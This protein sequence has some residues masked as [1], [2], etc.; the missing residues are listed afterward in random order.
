[1]VVSGGPVS[2]AHV[3]VVVADRL[4]AP[5]RARRLKVWLPCVRPVNVFVPAVPV[6]Q[7]ANAAASTRQEKAALSLAVQLKV[8]VVEVAIAP[9]VAVRLRVGAAVSV[10]Q[11]KLAGVA[12]TL[13]APSTPR[14]AKVCG[15]SGRL[16]SGI[17]TGDAQAAKAAPSRLHSSVAS[18]SV[19]IVKDAAPLFGSGGV[20]VNAVSGA[21]VSTVQL[22]VAGVGSVLPAESLAATLKECEPSARLPSVTGL[23]QAVAAAP[24]SEHWNVDG[25]VDDTNTNCADV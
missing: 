12:S 2:T 3:N 18:G 4:P 25:L 20:P 5:S 10:V 13:P 9:G 21:T 23:V 6:P 22:N 1:M 11:V 19:A 16:D 14:A 15:P 17:E 8:T 24:S 7:E